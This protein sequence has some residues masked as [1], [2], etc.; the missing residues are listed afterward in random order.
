M[1]DKFMAVTPLHDLESYWLTFF[2]NPVSA[3][4][5]MA[6]VTAAPWINSAVVIG[7]AVPPETALAK[8]SSAARLTSKMSACQHSSGPFPFPSNL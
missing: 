7:K 5:T 2:G 4:F 1:L 6:S 8:D 3:D